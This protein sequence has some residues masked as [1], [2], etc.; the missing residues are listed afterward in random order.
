VVGDLG[1]AEPSHHLLDPT[2]F[3]VVEGHL[4]GLPQDDT[5]PLQHLHT[6]LAGFSFEAEHLDLEVFVSFAGSNFCPE[7]HSSVRNAINSM[8]SA[9]SAIT[10][11]VDH[12]VITSHDQNA[13]LDQY[14][15]APMLRAL[16]KADPHCLL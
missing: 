1:S 4:S 7:S 8:R 13:L 5:V 2:K 15:T 10:N 14:Q 9:N 16:R 3:D 11:Y 6:S 12:V